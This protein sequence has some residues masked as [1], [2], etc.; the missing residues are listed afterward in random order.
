MPSEAH[1]D[2]GEAESR[3][4]SY[5]RVVQVPA[6]A[7]VLSNESRA[8]ARPGDIARRTAR[9]T[10]GRSRYHSRKRTF[11]APNIGRKSRAAI[12]VGW[13]SLCSRRR[14]PATR[15]RARSLAGRARNSQRDGDPRARPSPA[16]EA[17]AGECS[18]RD[19]A[20]TA[21]PS[22]GD[23]PTRSD[24]SAGREGSSDAHGQLAKE[25]DR[26][27]IITQSGKGPT[28]FTSH[29]TTGSACSSAERRGREIRAP[30]TRV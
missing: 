28:D 13:R 24:G 9:S 26:P 30:P 4:L 11:M 18:Q 22:T 10:D 16:R 25:C 19:G 23:V 17:S 27:G 1:R 2:G 12:G 5:L 3:A 6:G 7:R 15:R 21:R 14:A 8:A 20:E 29:A